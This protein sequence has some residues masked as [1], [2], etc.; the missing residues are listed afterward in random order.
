[1]K[2]IKYT[3]TALSLI[4]VAAI[5]CSK[6]DDIYKQYIQPGGLKYPAK[7]LNI[8]AETGFNKVTLSWPVPLDPSIV[9]ARIYWDNY[10]DSVDVDYSDFKTK[11]GLELAES[12]VIAKLDTAI[13][14]IADLK[15][16]AYSFVIINFDRLGNKSLAAEYTAT[17]YG[18]NWLSAHS[19]RIYKDAWYDKSKKVANCNFGDNGDDE[20]VATRFRYVDSEGKIV[21]S[22][23]RMAPNKS[24]YAIHDPKPGKY[25]EISSGFLPANGRDTA[26]LDWTRVSTPIRYELSNSKWTATVTKDAQKGGALANLFDG[27]YKNYFHFKKMD[28]V[29]IAID[30]HEEADQL[31][32]LRA[33]TT[34]MYGTSYANR[35]AR[36]ISIYL[37]NKPFDPDDAD[38]ATNYG[39]PWCNSVYYFGSAAPTAGGAYTKARYIAIVVKTFAANNAVWAE[40]TPWGYIES[41]AN[42]E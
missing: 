2:A 28:F 32:T 27:N 19:E 3:I 37:G 30:T 25:F 10:T 8:S 24:A 21:E 20:L 12:P 26:W 9:R 34:T 13:V 42:M 35:G 41:E 6:Q 15:D 7:A 16:R 38:W 14:K 1:M 17:P 40:L 22:V 4:L 33:L 11:T 5:S 31:M 18:A 23:D 29:V 39:T 36:N